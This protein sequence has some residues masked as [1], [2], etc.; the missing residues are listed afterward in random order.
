MCRPDCVVGTP[1]ARLHGAR[2]MRCVQTCGQCPRHA[3]AHFGPP[4]LCPRLAQKLVVSKVRAGLGV[5]RG[6]VSGGGSLAA[7]LDDFY[8][9]RQLAGA[10]AA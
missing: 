10:T 4:D 6:I 7:H 8:E 5:S 2:M 9:V 1:T 3:P